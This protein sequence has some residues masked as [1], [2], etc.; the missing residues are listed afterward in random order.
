MHRKASKTPY[1]QRSSSSRP[2]VGVDKKI[3][4]NGV[5]MRFKSHD[6]SG[7][8]KFPSSSRVEQL[9]LK[10]QVAG[11]SPASGATSKKSL[12]VQLSGISGWLEKL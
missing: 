3:E 10:R 11:S 4:S 12:A 2:R 7:G 1:N 9:S 5:K 8:K 6:T